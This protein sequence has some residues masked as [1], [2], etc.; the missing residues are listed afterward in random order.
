MLK[1]LDLAIL[2]VD[3]PEH[4]LR[5]GEIGTIV[6]AHGSEA[7]E[8]EFVGLE[9]ETLAI[10]TLRADQLRAVEPHEIPHD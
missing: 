1:E 6:I 8:V 7:Y 9:G 4:G 5:A 2:T 3:I 10:I